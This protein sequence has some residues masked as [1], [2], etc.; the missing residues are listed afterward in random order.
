MPK[1]KQKRPIGYYDVKQSAGEKGKSGKGVK[2]AVAEAVAKQHKSVKKGEKLDCRKRGNK[3]LKECI[4][5][6]LKKAREKEATRKATGRYAKS[7]KGT[8]QPKGRKKPKK[9]TTKKGVVRG[10]I[11]IASQVYRDD[12]VA[13]RGQPQQQVQASQPQG[14]NMGFGSPFGVGAVFNQL[15]SAG[16]REREAQA[17]AQTEV[18]RRF[19]SGKALSQ[20]IEAQDQT[21]TQQRTQLDILRSRF[22]TGQFRPPQPTTD[23]GRQP[24]GMRGAGGG[25]SVGFASQ[26]G[27]SREDIGERAKSMADLEDA[28]RD[29]DF[30]NPLTIQKR[31]LQIKE[32]DRQREESRA[33][34]KVGG[35]K[36]KPPPPSPL[37]EQKPI[38]ELRTLS[39]EGA[40]PKIREEAKLELKRRAELTPTP[41]GANP[42]SSLIGFLQDTAQ[43]RGGGGAGNDPN[44]PYEY[45][46]HGAD[47]PDR[48]LL[49]IPEV[50][51]YGER[52]LRDAS[53]YGEISSEYNKETQKREYKWR[54]P[55]DDYEESGRYHEVPENAPLYND[56][57]DF[58]REKL[59]RWR[60]KRDFAG[61]EL[62]FRIQNEEIDSAGYTPGVPTAEQKPQ[63]LINQG[64]KRFVYDLLPDTYGV[65][66]AEEKRMR[67][68][69]V[70]KEAKDFFGRPLSINQ[71]IEQLSNREAFGRSGGGRRSALIGGGF[72]QLKDRV[73][74]GTAR[75]GMTPTTPEAERLE[76]GRASSVDPVEREEQATAVEEAIRTPSDWEGS[77]DAFNFEGEDPEGRTPRAEG[78]EPS[79]E[80]LDAVVPI[81]D[82]DVEDLSSSSSEESGIDLTDKQTTDLNKLVKRFKN[83]SARGRGKSEVDFSDGGVSLAKQKEV[84]ERMSN[85]Y[86]EFGDDNTDVN[87]EFEGISG[88]NHMLAPLVRPVGNPIDF[89]MAKGITADNYFGM[90]LDGEGTNQKKIKKSKKGFSMEVPESDDWTPPPA[91]WEQAV[92]GESGILRR[93]QEYHHPDQFDIDTG[94]PL[95]PR[96]E[97][98]VGSLGVEA[99]AELTP[100]N[101]YGRFVSTF[102]DGDR[103]QANW[104]PVVWQPFTQSWED[105]P[106]GLAGVYA[107]PQQIYQSSL[108]QDVEGMPQPFRTTI[109]KG[110]EKGFSEYSIAEE[111]GQYLLTQLSKGRGA[112]G[113][114]GIV[115]EVPIDVV[116]GEVVEQDDE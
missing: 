115:E 24:Y 19:D 67:D 8:K 78:R 6:A 25:A 106:K 22:D 23:R 3:T 82:K 41:R 35:G 101:Q 65:P 113:D 37:V 56:P 109:P 44:D 96:L 17:K 20:R 83:T 64:G 52:H 43:I 59:G 5:R 62:D 40:T 12:R 18:Q 75:A 33:K 76:L 66:F 63:V 7:R 47:F 98:R 91:R 80:V 36:A 10:G 116:G 71:R 84:Y 30:L 21:I 1:A 108:A 102:T 54:E 87:D 15:Q 103:D 77:D 111:D 79:P 29:S 27:L 114:A 50:D 51:Y 112:G 99:F 68:E 46:G 28:E 93:L 32:L 110:S 42:S 94:R 92:F 57:I 48:L 55:R 9:H 58:A 2:K 81:G 104:R 11:P 60:G 89:D 90:A 13:G 73:A 31:A 107:R 39:S 16:V 97:K 100:A 45:S 26:S 38:L 105:R 14:V 74:V 34:T 61:Y 53:E 69:L 4:E 88:Y 49:S 72:S 85:L 86:S 70:S 95:A